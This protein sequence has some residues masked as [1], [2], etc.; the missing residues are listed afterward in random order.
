MPIILGTQ[1]LSVYTVVGDLILSALKL[2]GIEEAG[3]TST[4]DDLNDGLLFLN[5]LLDEWGI[6]R[7]K[8]YVRQED[9]ITLTVGDGLYTM[10]PSGDIDTQ[11]PVKIEQGYLRDTTLTPAIDYFLDVTMQQDQYN[12]MP[13]K[14]IQTIPTRLFGLR[15]WPMWSLYLDYLPNKAYEM[16]LFSAKS[17]TKFEDIQTAINLPDGYEAALTYNLAVVFSSA[18][19]KEPPKVVVA[20]AQMLA[21]AISAKN[22]EIPRIKMQGIPGTRR[23]GGSIYNPFIRG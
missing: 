7:S 13:I 15:S 1:Q 5:L 18:F 17:F 9:I 16:H 23:I 22:Y 3:E 6:D 21:Q 8:I 11:A 20:K 2:M 19:G 10:G 14:T 4:S 12:E